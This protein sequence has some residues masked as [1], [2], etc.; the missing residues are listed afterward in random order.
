MRFHWGSAREGI[1]DKRGRVEIY[2][3]PRDIWVGIYVAEDAIYVCPIPFLVIRVS[4]GSK[5]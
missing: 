1:A 3:E 2:P 5:P 4:R